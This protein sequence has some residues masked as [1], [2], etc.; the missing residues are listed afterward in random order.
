[1]KNQ[2][3]IDTKKE[4][5]TA[6]NDVTNKLDDAIRALLNYHGIERHPD[7]IYLREL[8]KTERLASKAGMTAVD[9]IYR[10]VCKFRVAVEKAASHHYNR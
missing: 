8:T 1:M 7:S 9:E 2:L 6:W 5:T 10:S 4:E 3:D